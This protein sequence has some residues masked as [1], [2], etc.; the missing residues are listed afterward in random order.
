MKAA[1]IAIALALTTAG[2]TAQN[3]QRHPDTGSIVG[4]GTIHRGV[5]PE[6]PDTWHIATADGRTLWPV[7]D[8]AFQVEGLRVRFKARERQG[9]VGICMAG[10]IVDL[11]HIEKI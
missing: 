11:T 2:C 8:V 7:D 3:A 4:A 5:G 9:A 6:C 1:L 10:T